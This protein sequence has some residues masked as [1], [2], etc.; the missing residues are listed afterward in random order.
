MEE[1]LVIVADR[2]HWLADAEAPRYPIGHACGRS[3][4]GVVPL[5]PPCYD[6]PRRH[7]REDGRDIRSETIGAILALAEHGWTRRER[8]AP[9]PGACP[10]RAL[11]PPDWGRMALRATASKGHPSTT[12]YSSSMATSGPA[13]YT[14]S[15]ASVNRV[16]AATLRLFRG[17]AR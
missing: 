1:L 12:M 16:G 11:R 9:S 17:A 13:R 14:S 6:S 7:L 2:P 8:M 4:N 5:Q 15:F 10:K 3:Q